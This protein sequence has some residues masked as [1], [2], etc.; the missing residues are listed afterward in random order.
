M[1]NLF[2]SLNFAK[3]AESESLISLITVSSKMSLEMAP[4]DRFEL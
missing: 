3:N 1:L 2:I 4:Y